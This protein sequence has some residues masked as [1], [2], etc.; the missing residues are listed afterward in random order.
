VAAYDV[1]KPLVIDPVLVYSTYLG[2]SGT[3]RA[4]GIAVDGSG[5]AYV[6]GDTISI[7]FPTKAPPAFAPYQS[8]LSKSTTTDCFVTKINT[9]VSGAASLVYSSYLGGQ[10]LTSAPASR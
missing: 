4:S 7:N 9:A 10:Q 5:N 6:T 1:K 8:T 2:G 3:D